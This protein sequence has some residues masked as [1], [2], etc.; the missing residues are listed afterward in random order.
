MITTLRAFFLSRLLREKLLLVSF[1]VLAALMWF[2]SF[3]RRAGAFWQ[4]QRATNQSL[5]EQKLWLTNRTAI[6]SA[7]RKAAENLVP[8]RTF[9]STGLLAEMQRLARDAG[10]KDPPITDA[11]DEPGEHSY[12]V[13]LNK[14]EW[15][16][17]LKFYQSIQEQSPYIGIQQFQLQPDR[18][19]TTTQTVVMRVSSVEIVK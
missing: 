18:G 3:G 4:Q 10:L 5:I 17:L 19:S 6:E 2:S 16:P 9:N 11:R 15:L 13:R 8:E 7:E 14:A 12:E 1:A